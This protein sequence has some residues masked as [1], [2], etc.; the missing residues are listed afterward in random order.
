MSSEADSPVLRELRELAAR[1][2]EMLGLIQTLLARSDPGPA[3]GGNTVSGDVSGVSGLPTATPPTTLRAV[4]AG[5]RSQSTVYHLLMFDIEGGLVCFFVSYLCFVVRS[6]LTHQ[7]EVSLPFLS[8]PL[9]LPVRVSILQH[10]IFSQ[11]THR[12]SPSA[13]STGAPRSCQTASD[14]SRYLSPHL[15]STP[16][17][18]TACADHSCL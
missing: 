6:V 12:P 2:T 14:E 1:Q 11:C 13:D 17:F 8:L 15:S 3:G 5:D 9:V 4:G 7:G 16:L 18:L 10:F